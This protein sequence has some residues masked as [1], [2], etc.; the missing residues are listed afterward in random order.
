MTQNY[1]TQGKMGYMLFCDGAIV[2][3]IKSERVCWNIINEPKHL[4]Q[5]RR[6]LVSG[7]SL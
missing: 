3:M 6:T 2:D 1:K 5:D 4:W 7:I